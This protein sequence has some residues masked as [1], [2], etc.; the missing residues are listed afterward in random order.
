MNDTLTII[1]L[2]LLAPF[3]VVVIVGFIESMVDA[4]KEDPFEFGV[5]LIALMAVAG[6]TLLAV[7]M[8]SM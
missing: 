4:L 8:Y 7:S 6:S 1:G 2:C 5:I 3:L